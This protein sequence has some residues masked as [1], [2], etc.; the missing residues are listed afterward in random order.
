[1]IKAG[2]TITGRAVSMMM[3]MPCDPYSPIDTPFTHHYVSKERVT[4]VNFKRTQ[5]NHSWL[6]WDIF[7]HNSKEFRDPFPWHL[8]W[9]R[10]CHWIVMTCYMYRGY[11]DGY[12]SF[13]SLS[14]ADAHTVCKTTYATYV[15]WIRH[16]GLST[17]SNVVPPS[18]GSGVES[19]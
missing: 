7:C 2:P 14:A 11:K 17:S 13:S 1:M 18:C 10:R 3:A 6:F 4:L 9:V 15:H 19:W 8:F 5:Q 12:L 16:H